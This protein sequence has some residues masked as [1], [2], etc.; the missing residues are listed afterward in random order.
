ML[1]LLKSTSIVLIFSI[2]L[3]ITISL[4]QISS[5][6]VEDSS[7]P[8]CEDTQAIKDWAEKNPRFYPNLSEMFG[9]AGFFGSIESLQYYNRPEDK[10]ERIEFD[11]KLANQYKQ[12]GANA[13]RM[14][15]SWALLQPENQYG[16]EWK[17]Y[18]QRLQLIS[19]AVRTPLITL[20]NT[21]LWNTAAPENATKPE[22]YPPADLDF[23][24][25]FIKAVVSRYG[26]TGQNLIHHWEIWNE[27]NIDK[28]FRVPDGKSQTQAYQEI[29]SAAYE[30]IKKTDLTATVLFTGISS[31]QE[32]QSNSFTHQ[33]LAMNQGKRFFDV[34]NIH[35]YG[36]DDW[37]LNRACKARKLLNSYGFN[38]IPIWI[39]ETGTEKDDR[40][41]ENL[42]VNIQE[43][44]SIETLKIL[45]VFGIEKLFWWSD[46][47]NSL[48]SKD[49]NPNQA[50][51]T[52]Q[53]MARKA[54]AYDNPPG[55]ANG[56]GRVDSEDFAF[57]VEDYLGEPVNNTDF[58]SDGR[59]DSEDFAILQAN[60]LR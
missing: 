43:K 49:G 33:V 29:L 60:Y 35:T 47:E 6:A 56:D 25:Q 3:G 53:E 28:F 22:V 55:D 50:Y 1:R 18:D 10:Q 34:F 17:F 20:K 58:N 4:F 41:I 37:L 14:P 16:Y 27:A 23:Y 40:S 11:T 8:N 46:W 30:A 5:F 21:P 54:K 51:F 2:L 13:G 59:V 12:V 7:Y 44:Y 36:T 26:P 42:V 24:R 52:Y 45:R 31:W 32:F 57:L 19:D 39:T 48:L 38:D 9:I 15:L